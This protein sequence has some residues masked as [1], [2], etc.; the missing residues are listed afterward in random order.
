MKIFIAVPYTGTKEQQE[1]RFNLVRTHA[2]TLARMGHYPVSPVLTFHPLVDEL[3]EV[4]YEFWI[5]LSKEYLDGCNTVHLIKAEGWKKSTGVHH[6][7]VR[8]LTLDIPVFLVP[9][10]HIDKPVLARDYTQP[11]NVRAFL[12]DTED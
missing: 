6:E 10:D 2:L 1:E 8:S 4:P 9:E 12:S 5:E 3:P 7:L 11:L